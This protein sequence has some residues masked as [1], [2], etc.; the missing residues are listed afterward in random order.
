[1]AYLFDHSDE[2]ERE[3]LA[4][5][6]RGDGRSIECFEAIGVGEGWR[7]LEVGAGAGSLAR[8]LCQRV[9]PRGRVVATDLETGFLGEL[10]EEN[11][12]IRRHDIL[13]DPLEDE[14]FELVHAR[15]VLEH[16]PAWRAALRRMLAATRPGGWL[17]V[18][19]ADL[20]SLFHATC[21]E[22]TEFARGYRAFVGTMCASGYQAD[23]GLHLGA[24]LREL[25]LLGVQVR[26]W[27][28]EWTGGDDPP[29]T[30]LLTFERLRDRVVEQGHLAR[31][32]ADRFMA[33]IRAP[34]FRAITGVHFA[35]WGRKA[36]AAAK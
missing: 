9:G 33:G 26:G 32:E 5:I 17:C 11:L 34:D 7:C 19:D 8:W 22:P 2:R 14:A 23:L 31:D 28:S 6:Q 3:R 16:L 1:V 18:E 27:T 10:K 36:G 15:K 20:L 21:S 12:E 25:G 30:W 24:A 4:S 35:A 13:S 29:S